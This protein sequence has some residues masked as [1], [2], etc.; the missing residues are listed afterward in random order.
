MKVLQ[1]NKF[2]FPF[3]GCEQLMFNTAGLL[4]SHGHEVEYFAMGHRGNCPSALSGFFPGGL[5]VSEH[6][7]KK[8]GFFGKAATAK[9]FYFFREGYENVRG[10]ARGFRPDVAHLHN[11]Y[12]HLS[13]SVAA[14]LK[15]SGVSTVL[16]LHDFKVVCPTY[17]LFRNGHICEQCAGGRFY[18]AVV[19]RCVR[20]SVVGSLTCAVE[21][22]LHRMLKMYEDNVDLFISPSRF[23][24]DKVV[25]MG[26]PGE[27]IRVLPNFVFAPEEQPEPGA[28][29]YALFMGRLHPT[30]GASV[31]VRAASMIDDPDFRLIIAGTGE[32]DDEL[33]AVAE[34]DGK[35][36]IEFSGFRTGS[37]LDSLIAGSKFGVVPSI[38]YENCPMVVLEFWMKGRAVIASDLGGLS[39]MISGGEGGI[40][41]EAG[42]AEKLAAAM[43][44]LWKDREASD[45]MG[46]RGYARAKEVYSPEKH[47]DGLMKIYREAIDGG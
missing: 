40:L 18:R 45:G 20:G 14:G 3:A 36:R 24:R 30:K 42:S 38:W 19:N 5:D 28:G 1:V 6:G 37:E 9:R 47:Y 44:G 15:R 11:I 35:G 17:S 31:L 16:T 46:K 22:Y 4:E 43:A 29:E 25:E 23:L 32:E 7:A 27:K 39:E 33:R 21:G 26:F 12:H 41:V 34:R 13:P 2:L 10:A 8:L